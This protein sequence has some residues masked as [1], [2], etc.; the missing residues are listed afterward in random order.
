MDELSAHKWLDFVKSFDESYAS[1]Y[2]L[3]LHRNSCTAY[4]TVICKKHLTLV[5][6]GHVCTCVNRYER[7]DKF[8]SHVF[9]TMETVKC[10]HAHEVKSNIDS[11]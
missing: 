7:I 9:N 5:V 10:E 1:E 6:R 3:S 8:I 4:V 2:H 11:Q